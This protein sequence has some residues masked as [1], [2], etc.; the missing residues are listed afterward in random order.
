MPCNHPLKAFPTGYLTENGKK[1]YIVCPSTAGDI[2]DAELANKRKRVNF[3]SVKNINGHLYL[4]DPVP[5]PCGKCEG[6]IKSIRSRWRDRMVLEAASLDPSYQECY[7][8]TLT[9]RDECLPRLKTGE[10]A[11]KK[12]DLQ[13]FFK[14]LRHFV[15]FR[16]Y[17][18]AEY[19]DLGK[20]PHYHI[21]YF[22]D[23]L[24]GLDWT[25]VNKAHSRVI[26]YCWP[27][28]MHDVEYAD[29]G[30]MAYVAGYVTK[31]LRPSD[32]PPIVR[33]FQL[34]SR[35]PGIGVPYAMA[36]LDVLPSG[37]VYGAFGDRK[38]YSVM[39][40]LFERFL[41]DGELASLKEKRIK[42]G[43]DQQRILEYI[44]HTRDPDK[45]GDELDSLLIRER[46]SLKNRDVY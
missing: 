4:V 6:C 1:D 38:R 13:K 45:I 32:D 46:E 23:R 36:N 21:V 43:K 31:K 30:C 17:A 12:G 15:S 26:E 3:A 40:R 8:I 29:V 22:G 35:R 9:Y 34:M 14:R 44:F 19:G 42:S 39:P 28:G 5:I 10:L 33:E 41:D 7:F 16:Y 25:G 27:F 2:L 18:C 37:L 20:R 24:V 11:L